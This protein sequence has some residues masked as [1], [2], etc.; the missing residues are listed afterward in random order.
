MVP[1]V[2]A[3][4]CH[5]PLV[6]ATTVVDWLNLAN[7]STSSSF[8]LTSD[9]G[10]VAAQGGIAV[11]AGKG[12]SYPGFPKLTELNAGSWSGETGFRDSVTGDDR[13]GTFDIRVAPQNEMTA[14]AL[15]LNVPT[16]REL[17]IAVGGLYRDS[18]GG[19]NSIITTTSGGG[20]VTFLQSLAWD[21][22]ATAFDQ[23]LEW[24][25]L[26]ATLTTTTGSNGESE[27]A[28]LRV[29]PLSG[30]NPQLMFMVPEGYA[31]GTGESISIG[32]GMVVP[33]P[34]VLTLMGMGALIVLAG[35]RR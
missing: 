10:L 17:I 2:L 28:F 6:A 24:D 32:V 14:Y 20:V 12:I 29:S 30:P 34:G 11:E 16:G 21:A 23:E 13:V 3:W 19:T 25:A 22:G 26:S 27:V 4:C 9:S 1:L 33:E 35:R 8:S 18:Q 31:M 7:G 15:T 5:E